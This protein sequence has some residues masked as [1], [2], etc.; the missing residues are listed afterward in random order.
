MRSSNHNPFSHGIQSDFIDKSLVIQASFRKLWVINMALAKNKMKHF[1]NKPSTVWQISS[2]SLADNMDGRG[3]RGEEQEATMHS[4]FL[5]CLSSKFYEYLWIWGSVKKC[6]TAQDLADLYL[7]K[8]DKLVCITQVRE[9]SVVS[10]LQI[11]IFVWIWR[12]SKP[13]H[14]RNFALQLLKDQKSKKKS[15]LPRSLF[16]NS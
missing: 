9:P 13:G 8:W 12:I 4:L 2:L 1:L 6:S 5:A 7:E 15:L 16:K 11:R 3:D 10:K 14:E